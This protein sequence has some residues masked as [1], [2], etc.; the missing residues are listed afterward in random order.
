LHKSDRPPARARPSAPKRVRRGPLVDLS[1]EPLH[2]PVFVRIARAF[3]ASIGAGSLAPG[4]L[5]PG[6]RTLALSL[7]VHRNT[8]LAAFRELLAEGYVVAR[9]GRGTFVADDLPCTRH[10]AAAD[11]AQRAMPAAP[12]FPY[13]EP[14]PAFALPEPPL[15]RALRLF[16]GMP[17]VELVPRKAYARAL[18]R[19]LD[20][21]R[22]EL[23][24]YGDAQGEPVLRRALA[25]FLRRERGL[26]VTESD[27]LVTRGSQMAL[28]LLGQVL[29]QPGDVIAVEG[30]GYPP[31]HRALA[32]RGAELVP[33]PVDAEGLSV[34]ALTA[35]CERRTVRAVYVT[36]HHQYPSTVTMS[37]AR[38][39][40]LLQLARHRGFAIIEDDYD[41][42]FHYE[43]RPVLP[44][45]SR[46]LG[47]V[48]YVGTLS[49]VLAPALRVGFLVAPPPL[50]R[51]AVRVRFDIDRQGDRVA[52]RALAELLDD[53][54]IGRHLLR[55][56]S[57]YLARRD[58][59][60]ARLRAALPDVLSFEVPRGGMA[61]WAE[62]RGP[63]GPGALADLWQ[64]RGVHVQ[65]GD[66]FSLL[67]PTSHLRIGYGGLR[68]A[69][70]AR[71]VDAMASALHAYRDGKRTKS[72]RRL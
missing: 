29:T 59:A 14:P 25:E 19:A 26:A 56:R 57:V 24:L 3:A 18:R 8:V 36:P 54:E 60:V 47:S 5:L 33:L 72:A 45:G 2:L 49:K 67:G 50:L 69:T 11:R 63:L 52:E 39:L 32:A 21:P 15:P 16:G 35:L 71:A 43:G 53:G 40:S 48:L 70:F 13:R 28:Y 6:T 23:L 34:A 68:E 20:A 55:A 4:A 31:A 1:A 17:D 30:L 12:A 41:H 62:V 42:E 37:A 10:D 44:L 58:H 7:G 61:L 27:I 51:A 66:A 22:A 38:R 65:R 64:A 46:D 9:P